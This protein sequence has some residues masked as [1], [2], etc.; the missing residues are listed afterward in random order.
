[1]FK[2]ISKYHY[3][4]FW[5]KLKKKKYLQIFFFSFALTQ[6]AD[7][8][9]VHEKFAYLSA[10]VQPTGECESSGELSLVNILYRYPYTNVHKYP[11]DIINNFIFFTLF[12]LCVYVWFFFTPTSFK[13]PA[14]RKRK[15]KITCARALWS[16][17]RNRLLWTV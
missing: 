3:L 12:H 1:M 8:A 15:Y 6:L 5:S 7:H 13:D 4:I 9:D 11:Q 16:S 10:P 17:K 14:R 2:I